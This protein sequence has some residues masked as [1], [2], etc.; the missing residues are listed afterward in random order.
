MKKTVTTGRMS[1]LGALGAAAVTGSAT[2][3]TN[4][5]SS[6]YGDD[7]S[8]NCSPNYYYWRRWR[9]QQPN[10]LLQRWLL[11]QQRLGRVIETRHQCVRRS[12]TLLVAAL[13]L[14]LSGCAG[15][16][17]AATTPVTP[18]HGDG[19]NFLPVYVQQLQQPPPPKDDCG[20]SLLAP[21]DERSNP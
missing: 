8:I 12:L 18:T 21:C 3:K 6:C 17:N 14:A 9:L 5:H 2:A 11:L 16:G 1:G 15:Q 10:R 13:A 4:S 7:Y 20:A 19:G